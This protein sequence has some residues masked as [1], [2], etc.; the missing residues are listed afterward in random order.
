MLESRG[1]WGCPEGYHTVDD[2]E[3][4]Q[5]YPNEGGCEYEDMILLTDRPGKDDRCANIDSICRYENHTAD[6]CVAM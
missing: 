3:T 1:E 4:G 5:C 6:V 2:D